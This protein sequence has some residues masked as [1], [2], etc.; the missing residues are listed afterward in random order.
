[1]F[2]ATE[3]NTQ[4]DNNEITSGDFWPVIQ[5]LDVRA[6][7]RLD[8]TITNER[9]EHAV[10]SAVIQVNKELKEWRV[11]QQSDGYSVLEDIPAEQ[12]NDKSEL[13][14][15]YQRAVY[16]FAKANL[17]ER[18]NDFDSTAKGTKDVGDLEDSATSFKRDGR[19]AIRD[20]LDESH[21]TV[22]LI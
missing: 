19:L 13:L 16:C 20:I 15:L 21:V 17:I 7:M 9:L 3:P 6:V 5:L 12:I 1:M 22:E 2:I 14:H 18:Y 4:A 10:V 11:T 8:G